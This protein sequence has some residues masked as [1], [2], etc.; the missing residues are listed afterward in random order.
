M[1]L[2]CHFTPKM[3]ARDSSYWLYKVYSDVCYSFRARRRQL[4]GDILVDSHASVA[5]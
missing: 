5:M 1:T 4:M 2:R 3:F